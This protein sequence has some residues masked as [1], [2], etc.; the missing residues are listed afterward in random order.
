MGQCRSGEKE[1]LIQLTAKQSTAIG[2]SDFVFENTPV[3]VMCNRNCPEI[4]LVGLKLGPFEEG[5][6]YEIQYWIAN[7]LERAGIA[8]FRD[9]ELLDTRKLDKILWKE[10]VQQ[11]RQVSHIEEDFYPRLRRFLSRL[12]KGANSSPERNAE[13]RKAEA[14][15]Q[16]IINI[17]LRKIV[18]LASSPEQTNEVL[19]DLAK[20]E[21]TLYNRLY[22]IISEWKTNITKETN[23]F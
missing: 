6:E 4:Q 8:R 12:K 10:K 9:E 13:Y 16:D 18:A 23:E 22:T 7:E 17:R 1:Q 20:E 11:A 3:R 15:A 21:R 5:K 2:D 19:N 14:V